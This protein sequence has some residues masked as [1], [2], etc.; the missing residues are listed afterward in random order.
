MTE[1]VDHFI[2]NK[3]ERGS[4][5]SFSSHDPATGNVV[6]QGSAAAEKEVNAAVKAAEKAFR[7]W[8]LLSLDERIAYLLRFKDILNADMDLLSET[9]SKETGKP[10]WESKS[11]VKIMIAKV[12]FSL[13][14]YRVRCA[15]LVR[16]NPPAKLI[17]KHK[18]HGVIA[19]LGPFNFPGHIPN[20][21]IIPALLAGN[22]LVFKPSE[23]TPQVAEV[24]IKCWEKT[25]LPPGVLNMIQGGRETGRLLCGHKDIQGLFFT[26]S[27]LTGKILSEQFAKTPDKILAMELG[28]NNP[29]IVSEVDDLEAAAY[30]VVHSAFITA[31]QRCSCARRLILPKG[32]QNDAFI[33]AVVKMSKRIKVGAY[34]DSPEPFM[35]PVISS[36]AAGH[37][38]AAQTTLK[39]KGGKIL[40]EMHL[41][42]ADTAL[43]SPCLIDTT[44]VRNRPDEEIFGPLL[45]LIRVPN[46]D[47]AL[48]EA[49]NT[50]YGLTSG[51]LSKRRDEYEKFYAKIKAGIVTWNAPTTGSSGAAPFGGIKH[52]G[53]FRPSGFYAADYC[54]YPVAV[55]EATELKL[56]AKPL[57]GIDIQ[58]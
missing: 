28:G 45:Q 34:T 5:A 46:F 56:P 39:N 7:T 1:K 4:G 58:R 14:G 50:S 15:E 52:S 44:E 48:V 35:G 17:T 54:S 40:V 27:W 53:N 31:G 47:A 18:P 11:E 9:I 49:N 21:H 2:D 13:E 6:W 42:K 57:P 26:G 19:I 30:A 16:D 29:L 23:Y 3:W 25:N 43:V 12:D 41:L 51:L 24:M 20:G 32:E 38:L 22:T 37:V 33:D 36:Q 10:L 8:S 55:N